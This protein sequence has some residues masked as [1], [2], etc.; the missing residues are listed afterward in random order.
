MWGHMGGTGPHLEVAEVAVAVQGGGS[1]IT[2]HLLM[3]LGL[4][5]LLSPGIGSSQ[6]AISDVFCLPWLGE[7]P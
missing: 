7:G 5:V 3:E 1:A 2:S 6:P 4:K